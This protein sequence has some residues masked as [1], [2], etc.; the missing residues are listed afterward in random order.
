[1]LLFVSNTIAYKCACYCP[2]YIGLMHSYACTTVACSQACV[3][4]PFD[5][6]KWSTS[7]VGYCGTNSINPLK[8]LIFALFLL[9]NV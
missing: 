1:M 3:T 2:Y 5:A 4:S 9:I 7:V 8:I 6:C